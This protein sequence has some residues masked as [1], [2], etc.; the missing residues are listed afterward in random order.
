MSGE[1][2][3]HPGNVFHPDFH[4]GHPTYFEISVRSAVHSGVI[5]ILP[6]HLGLQL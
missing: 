3:S 6:F 5:H 1:S 4:N 2:S